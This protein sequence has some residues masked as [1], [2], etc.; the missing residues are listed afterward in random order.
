VHVP[1]GYRGV[2]PTHDLHDSRQRDLEHQ[3]HGRGRVPGIV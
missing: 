1:L 2:R 3:E